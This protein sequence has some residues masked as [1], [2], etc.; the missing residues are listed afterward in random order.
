MSR[1]Q[2]SAHYTDQGQPS[3]FCQ[4]RLVRGVAVS[5]RGEARIPGARWQAQGNQKRREQVVRLASSG[6]NHNNTSNNTNNDN[7]KC[8]T[9][10]K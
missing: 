4:V 3:L 7:N 6:I 5:G 10:E 9:C 1:L 8:Y 2:E